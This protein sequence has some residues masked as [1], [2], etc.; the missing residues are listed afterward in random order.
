MGWV[1][2]KMRSRQKKAMMMLVDLVHARLW[3][4]NSGSQ[5]KVKVAVAKWWDL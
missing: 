3:E 4:F 5:T 1:L 2:L